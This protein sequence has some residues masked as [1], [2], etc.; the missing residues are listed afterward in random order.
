MRMA[1]SALWCLRTR[2][3]RVHAAFSG[4]ST[5]HVL[6]GRG[7]LA[8]RRRFE[9]EV[10]EA[11]EEEEEEVRAL[12]EAWWTSLFVRSTCMTSKH[13]VG[14]CIREKQVALSMAG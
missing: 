6:I 5:D 8:G 2:A 13:G 11:D 1:F 3:W 9:A 14:Y 12:R 7:G 10:I 4:V